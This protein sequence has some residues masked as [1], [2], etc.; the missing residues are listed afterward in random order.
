MSTYLNILRMKEFKYK[1][2]LL[3][4]CFTL[5]VGFSVFVS[6]FCCCCLIHLYLFLSIRFHFIRKNDTTY[7]FEN[8]ELIFIRQKSTLRCNSSNSSNSSFDF[9]F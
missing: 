2:M 9:H 3:I 1:E 4:F 7:K 6:L 8:F 5:R